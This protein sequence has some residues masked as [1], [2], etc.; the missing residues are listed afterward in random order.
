MGRAS[1]GGRGESSK[2]VR[3]VE[4]MGVRIG[5]WREKLMR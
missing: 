2:A 5:E 4:A 3:V 1:K